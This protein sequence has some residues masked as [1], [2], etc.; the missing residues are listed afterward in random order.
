MFIAPKLVTSQVFLRKNWNIKNV[1]EKRRLPDREICR[2]NASQERHKR[3]SQE[4][5]AGLNTL[6]VVS[7]DVADEYRLDHEEKREMR[8]EKEVIVGK[9][10]G[11]VEEKVF[12]LLIEV[13]RQREKGIKTLIKTH[14]VFFFFYMF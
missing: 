1:L 3:A 13:F 11:H 4:G 7:D 8:S 14:F 6:T 5:L 12:R 9:I 10:D 2:E